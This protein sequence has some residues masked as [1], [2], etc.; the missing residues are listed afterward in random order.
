M[1]S[2]PLPIG[3]ERTERAAESVVIE[4]IRSRITSLGAAAALM[5]LTA[6]MRCRYC[7]REAGAVGLLVLKS[8]HRSRRVR[9]QALEL[10]GAHAELDIAAVN[11]LND[12]ALSSDVFVADKAVEVIARAGKLAVRALPT[13]KRMLAVSATYAVLGAIETIGTAAASCATCLRDLSLNGANDAGYRARTVEVLSVIAPRS[14]CLD[15]AVAAALRSGEAQLVSTALC[16]LATEQ[17]MTGEQ[18]A[19]AEEHLETWATAGRRDAINYVFRRSGY[20]S[21]NADVLVHKAR[22]ANVEF[23]H[24]ALEFFADLLEPVAVAADFAAELLDSTSTRVLIA[25]TDVLLVHREAY[26]GEDLAPRFFE[27]LRSH[28]EFVRA[29]AVSALSAFGS[30]GT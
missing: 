26:H 17:R 29:G 5:E 1:K 15:E 30:G 3:V 20:G 12:A 23:Q 25:A 2:E 21:V 4:E 10:V 28:D 16:V 6:L 13:V 22:S 8:R 14:K 19:A 11:T 9:L 18:L 24:A 27:L 7:R